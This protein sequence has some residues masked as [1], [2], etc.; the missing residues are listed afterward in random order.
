MFNLRNWPFTVRSA[1][2]YNLNWGILAVVFVFSL[3]ECANRYTPN[4]VLYVL[5]KPPFIKSSQRHVQL[6]NTISAWL[7]LTTT[8]L[9]STAH[10]TRL[11]SPWAFWSACFLHGLVMIT[12]NR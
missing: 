2:E 7:I 3:D 10:L 8:V 5:E 4:H 1:G 6:T 9:S 11:K 12:P